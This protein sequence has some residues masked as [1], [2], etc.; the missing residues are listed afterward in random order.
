[1]RSSGS[2]YDGYSY[3]D[4][5]DGSNDYEEDLDGKVWR[6]KQAITERQLAMTTPPALAVSI[7]PQLFCLTVLLRYCLPTFLANMYSLSYMSTM[8][9]T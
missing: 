8:H 4:L 3:N 1:V 2:S 6:A 9:S 5:D 7:S